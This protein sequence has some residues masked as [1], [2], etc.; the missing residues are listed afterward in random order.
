MNSFCLASTCGTL[1]LAP[2]PG[3]VRYSTRKSLDEPWKV[4]WK[5]MYPFSR[6]II[7]KR[8][9]LCFLLAFSKESCVPAIEVIEVLSSP[10]KDRHDD[11]V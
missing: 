3:P 8:S 5:V 7:S 11:S 2:F 9:E 10:E 1:Y 4:H 6:I